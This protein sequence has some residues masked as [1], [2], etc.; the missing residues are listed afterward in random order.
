[1]EEIKMKK[2]DKKMYLN[3]KRIIAVILFVISLSILSACEENHWDKVRMIDENEIWYCEYLDET[4]H[5][6]CAVGELKD[7]SKKRNYVF[8]RKVSIIYRWYR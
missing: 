5:K 3:F 8:F 2:E 6:E 1:M 4:I 7:D